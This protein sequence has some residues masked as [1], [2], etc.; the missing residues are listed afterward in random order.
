MLALEIVFIFKIVFFE[1]RKMLG[2]ILVVVAQLC[3]CFPLLCF[4]YVKTPGTKHPPGW[5][6]V[7]PDQIS[8]SANGVGYCTD[9]FLFLSNEFVCQ[10]KVL[11]SEKL[12]GE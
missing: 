2:P 4:G 9:V 12:K 5:V 3:L 6:Q 1:E 11:L 10:D 8:C 7:S